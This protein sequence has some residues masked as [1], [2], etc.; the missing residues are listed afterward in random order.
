MTFISV[1]ETIQRRSWRGSTKGIL[2]SLR[3]EK[4]L[5]KLL[6]K[7]LPLVADEVKM[8]SF[9]EGRL[10]LLTTSPTTSQEVYLHSQVI[11][12]ELNGALGEMVVER[13]SFRTKALPATAPA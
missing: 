8:H 2:L 11:L 13:I 6:P 5:T 9:R 4:I 1:G 3:I 12:K 10:S 7:L